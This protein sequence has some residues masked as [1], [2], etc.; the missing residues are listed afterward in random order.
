MV[1]DPNTG[2]RVSRPNPESEWAKRDVPE[3]RIVPQELFDA[4]QAQL[5]GR[6]Q[7]AKGGSIRSNNRPKRLLSGLL[8]CG[9][10]GSGMAVAGVDK[11]GRTRLRCSAH[12]NSG[13]C[14]DP[15][16]F[17]LDEVEWLA[18][19]SLT[20]E[21]ATPD[22]I[23]LY[24]ERYLKARIAD[25]ANENRRRTEI[26]TRIAA[27]AK[28]NDRLLDLLMAGKGDQDAVD[29]R[30]KE[31]GRERDDLK[32]Q[33]ARLPK[34]RSIIL[35]PSAIKHLA[36]RL[37]KKSGSYLRSRRAQLEGTLHLLDDIGELGPIVRE[38]IHAIVLYRDENDGGIL[39]RVEAN[40]APF[41]QENGKPT[42]AVVVVAEEGF[43][44]PTQGL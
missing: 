25:D 35:H 20:K 3:L 29:A 42:G 26:E 1:K 8:K 41:I 9:A 36:D 43:E 44:P 13:A 18:I 17:Y 31:Q 5:V 23:K 37:T 21:L 40:L 27:I 15:K 34:G 28:D 33:L 19:S 6:A 14:S 7:T 12:T 4:V 32:Q 39:I 38:L 22:L 30:M 2:R 10:C 16:T 24:A 11:S